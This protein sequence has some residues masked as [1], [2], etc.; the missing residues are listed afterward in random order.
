MRHMLLRVLA[1]G[2]AAFLLFLPLDLYVRASLYPDTPALVVALWRVGGAAVIYATWLA[3]RARTWTPNGILLAGAI[4]MTFSL[5]ALAMLSLELGGL[6][7]SYLFS[8]AFYAVGLSTFLPTHW[9]SALSMAAPAILLFLGAILAGVALSPTLRPQFDDP[10]AVAE[11]IQ[12]TLRIVG[13]VAFAGVS[14]HILWRART[15]LRDQSRLGRYLLKRPLGKGGMNEVWLAWD[16]TLK[17]DVALKLLHDSHPDDT[18]RARFER[19]ARATSSLSSPHTVK[20]F[21]FGASARGT[22]WMAMEHLR[23]MDLDKMIATLGPID[24]RRAV[25]FAR[26]AATALAEAHQHGLVHRDVKPANLMAL[27]DDDQADFLKV[28]D[29]G[30]ARHIDSQEATLTLVG[31]VVGTPAFMSPEMLAGATPDPRG[32]VWSFG[33]TLYAMLTGTLPF[34]PAAYSRHATARRRLVPPSERLGRPLPAGLDA[35]VMRCMDL[36]ASRRPEHGAALLDALLALPV[37]PW[38]LDDARAWWAEH[39]P[40]LMEEAHAA[41][42]PDD[43]E[44]TGAPTVPGHPGSDSPATSSS[45]PQGAIA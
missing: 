36:D 43:P 39:T 42:P 16:T 29:F 15:R 26:Q 8:P 41:R 11:F 32:D 35:L 5:L 23:G 22:L 17:R 4:A 19:E 45:S 1:V 14:G 12:N 20:V 6:A 2:G 25:H 30:I 21:D 34:E 31:M 24:P 13:V 38:T 40:T 10:R 9:R 37:A 44:S 28:L 27:S 33:A 3:V 7:S 18:R